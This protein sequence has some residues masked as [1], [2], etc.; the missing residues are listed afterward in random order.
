MVKIRRLLKEPHT[1]I[2]AVIGIVIIVTLHVVVHSV[3]P[4]E[5][6]RA[7]LVLADELALI[8]LDV[9]HSHLW[10]DC[11]VFVIASIFLTWL[12]FFIKTV[13]INPLLPP[14]I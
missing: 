7:P 11:D 6:L 8:V 9:L 1:A 4:L 10:C 14:K 12:Q 13:S 2:L 5:A 3:L